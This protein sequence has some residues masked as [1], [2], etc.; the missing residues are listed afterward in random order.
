[1]HELC[2]LRLQN[3]STVVLAVLQVRNHEMRHIVR[4]RRQAAGRPSLHELEIL[5][6]LRHLVISL[7]HQRLQ[8]G[9]QR[10]AKRA[11]G[12]AQRYENVLL[13]VVVE[14]HP[15]NALHDVAGECGSIIRVRRSRSRREDFLRHMG[16]H[17]L[18]QRAHVRGVGDEQLLQRLLETRRVCH[19]VLHGDGLAEGRGD[20]EVEIVV[21]VAV[22]VDF[23]LL[24]QLHHSG[25][26]EGLGDGTRTEERGI[27]G[28]GLPSL[29]LG[30]AIAFGEKHL[31]VLHDGDHCARDVIALQ[32]NRNEPVKEGFQIFL[33][34]LGRD[35]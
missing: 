17:I 4:R 26:G 35:P 19:Q 5:R 21:H 11:V 34:E 3:A 7:R 9:G 18:L 1:V 15:R 22:Q 8:I 20:L 25:P 10:L 27:D 14:R 23:A 13:D 24:D 32:F 28:D 16:L 31:A 33:S 12:H 30:I 2:R 6:R 29:Y